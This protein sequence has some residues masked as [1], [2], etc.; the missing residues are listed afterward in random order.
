M[1]L[2]IF[3]GFSK[4]SLEKD[5]FRNFPRCQMF[6]V[7][8][9]NG[10]VLNFVELLCIYKLFF[11]FAVLFFSLSFFMVIDDSCLSCSKRF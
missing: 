6:V 5:T 8:D 7:K 10:N 9:C 4:I 1:V 2:R 3:C 11:E